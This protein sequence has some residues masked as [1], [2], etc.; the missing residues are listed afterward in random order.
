MAVE[1]G[2]L[3]AE[4][5]GQKLSL[6]NVALNTIATVATLFASGLIAYMVFQH[7]GE[8][9]DASKELA[10]AM[11]E[12]AMANREQNCLLIFRQEE[13]QAQSANC[14]AVSR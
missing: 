9:K 3:N 7:T 2:E 11:R 8:T 10:G 4:I 5:A 12:L 1:N 6:K 13:R 14:K